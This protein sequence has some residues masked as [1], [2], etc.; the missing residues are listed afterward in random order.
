MGIVDD[1]TKVFD[2]DF[3]MDMFSKYIDALPQFQVY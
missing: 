2:K 3:M 1:P